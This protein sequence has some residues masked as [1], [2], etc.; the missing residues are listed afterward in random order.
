MEQEISSAIESASQF[1]VFLILVM[2][3]YS[4]LRLNE[5]DLSDNSITRSQLC[6]RKLDMQRAVM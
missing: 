4:R 1:F 5:R 2:L 3:D 6:V